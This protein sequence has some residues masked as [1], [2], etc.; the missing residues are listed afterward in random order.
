MGKGTGSD[1]LTGRNAS[2][3]QRERKPEVG[4]NLAIQSLSITMNARLY[5]LYLLKRQHHLGPRIQTVARLKTFSFK[6]GQ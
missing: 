3:K 5:L 1:G 6:P 2:T 4:D